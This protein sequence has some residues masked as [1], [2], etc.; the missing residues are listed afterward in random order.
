MATFTFL[1][2]V[3]LVF[4]GLI[5]PFASTKFKG[6]DGSPASPRY[7]CTFRMLQS[8]PDIGRITEAMKQTAK[9]RW[10][11]TLPEPFHW[12]LKN[13]DAE[14]KLALQDGGKGKPWAQGFWILQ[15]KAYPPRAPRLSATLPDG[16]FVDFPDSGDTLNDAR[17][18][19]KGGVDV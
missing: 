10:G 2:P 13:G 19:L 8:H 9:E 4:P 1:T 18:Y 5:T 12:A 11:D 7:S 15:A 3:T 14:H 6:D 17:Q 16:S